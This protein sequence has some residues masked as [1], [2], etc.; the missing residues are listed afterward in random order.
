MENKKHEFQADCDRRSVRKQGEILNLCK[1]NF[2]ALKLKNFNDEINNFFINGCTTAKFGITWSSSWKSQRNGRIKD[3][4]VFYLRHYCKT[5]N[6]R[7]RIRTLFWNLLVRYRNCKMRLIAWMIQENFRMLNQFAV[8]IPTLPVD[9][10]PPHPIPEGMI[11]RS[12]GMLSRRKGPPSIC[13]TH[14]TLGNFFLQIQMLLFQHIIRRNWI[15]G[16]LE[17]KSRFTH[18]QLEKSERQT[19]D[20][21]QRCQSGQSANNSVIFSGGDSFMNYGT[22]QQ[23]LQI[24]DLHFDKFPAPATF[25]CWKIRFKTE[26][27]SCW[28]SRTGAMH[29]I[30]EVEMVHTVDDMMSSSSTQGIQM[31][32]FEVLDARI[33]SA[34][35]RI[36][37]K[38]L[39]SK[40]E[41]FWRNKRPRSR[42]VSFVEDRLL[43]LIRSTSG[44]Q[45]P[46]ILSRMLPTFS[47]LVFEMW[48]YSR[49]RLKVRRS[50]NVYDE[51]PT[52]WHLGMIVHVKNS[53]V[54]E[55]QDCSGIGWPGDSSQEKIARLPQI[56][57]NGEK[58]YRAGDTK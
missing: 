57:D 32:N 17:Q 20:Q 39:T 34:L 29:W 26:V 42:T 24:S 52:W 41:T 22:E 6:N 27:C 14:G 33:A 12:I 8:E 25:A 1:K 46:M 35:K 36:I 58:K 15:H 16:V 7:A 28:H 31:P 48:W 44:S 21:D 54:W 9:Q 53:S 47:V 13:D 23:R 3:V 11:S 50:S 51:N 55:T 40:E 10:C 43:I 30:K 45:D 37:H 2:N 19:Q 38:I 5:K 18:L 49:I 4:S 56:E